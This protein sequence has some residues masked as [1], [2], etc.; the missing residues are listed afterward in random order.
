MGAIIGGMYASGYPAR[1]ID[2]LARI[3]P[4]PSLFRR[5]APGRRLAWGNLLPVVAWE[6]GVGG[7]SLQT[8]AIRER[9]VNAL[10]NAALL[11]GN[12]LARGDF[13][14]LPIPFRAVATDLRDRAAIPLDSGD[15]AQA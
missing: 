5:Y 13:A 1:I 4:L 14:R 15:L 8:A 10:F 2:S 7:F 6:Q 11:R 3:L 9:E 12:L